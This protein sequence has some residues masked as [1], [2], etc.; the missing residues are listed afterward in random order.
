MYSEL[1]FSEDWSSASF[2]TNGWT[3]AQGSNW[4]I[5]TISGN[6]APSAMFG[7][8]P[9]LT[10][11]SETLTS[12]V[13]A[14]RYA[15]RLYLSYDIYLDN[16]G[17]TTVNQMAVEVWDG[18]AWIQLKNYSNSG[19]FYPMDRRRI[20]YISLFGHPPEIQVQGIR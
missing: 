17:T 6:P 14:P 5:S 13:I 15:P 1:I 9:Q 8:S 20:R 11:Y 7:N 4:I 2:A 18:N 12:P 19:G 16:F 10:D 3:A